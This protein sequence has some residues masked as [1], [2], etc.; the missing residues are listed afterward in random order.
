[1]SS[2]VEST[3]SN[4]VHTYGNA[5]QQVSIDE[6]WRFFAIVLFS[7]LNKV[8]QRRLLWGNPSDKFSSWFV[9]ALMSCKRFEDIL[10][11]LHWEDSALFS[12]E[13][14]NAKN[15]E[16]CF[17][18]VQE[19]EGLLSERFQHHYGC[20]QS[21]DGDEQG[22]PAKCYHSAIQYNG[23]KP[24]K[25]FFK[26]YCLN[27]SISKYMHNFYL[28]RGKDSDKRPGIS[29]SA[30]PIVKLTDHEMY[31]GK[32]HIVYVD[33]YFNSI[34]LCRYLLE[35][36]SIHTVGTLRT[37]RIPKQLVP[38]DWWFKKSTKIQRG[39]MKSRQ[40]A[41]SLFVT[42]WYDKK[43][44]NMLHTFKTTKEPVARHS[45]NT[46]SKAY[47]KIQIQRPTVVRAYNEGMGGTDAFDQKL[48]YYRPSINTKRW[49]HRI[50]FHL[51][52]C[53]LINAHI[54]YKER[55]GL[56][57]H[58]PLDDLFGFTNRILDGIVVK[59]VN[60]ADINDVDDEEPEDEEVLQHSPV[61][62]MRH[63]PPKATDVSRHYPYS[64]PTKVRG[65]RHVN[66]VV[67]RGPGCTKKVLT[68]C[69]ECKV[70]LCLDL[71]GGTNCWQKYHHFHS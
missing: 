67:C 15:K 29:A 46:T 17:W 2:F 30:F 49:P 3:N 59:Y 26:L 11:C 66:R 35:Q 60:G 62:R 27:D 40:V 13:E 44:V 23:D 52:Q 7:G 6:L 33:N 12:K 69:H 55:L 63:V 10:R 39:S 71:I 48:S 57:K 65:T 18:R 51:F 50:F 8:P 32:N 56:Q 4:G 70:G 22:I 25:Y 9:K 34:A 54:I 64:M 47:E 31:H 68:F 1:M 42:S 61:K 45:K 20:G 21:L 36:R 58:D 16:D 38:K 28:F 5:W 53:S 43:P 14:I 41:D 37:N 24:Y 19:L